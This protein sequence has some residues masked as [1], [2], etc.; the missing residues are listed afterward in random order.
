M[1]DRQTEW[2]AKCVFSV[3]ANFFPLFTVV[4]GGDKDCNCGTI[5]I[6]LVCS[7]LRFAE[8]KIRFIFRFNQIDSIQEKSLQFNG[9]IVVQKKKSLTQDNF[10]LNFNEN[11]GF[12]FVANSVEM[13]CVSRSVAFIR[14]RQ[15]QRTEYTQQSSVFRKWRTHILM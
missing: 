11:N 13:Y 8:E 6:W 5:K 12:A 1:T 10:F 9:S 7:G 15:R 3:F 2:F 14:H 4:F